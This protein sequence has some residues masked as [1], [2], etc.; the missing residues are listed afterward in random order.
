MKLITHLHPVPRLRMR[1]ALPPFSLHDVVLRHGDN[2]SN[3]YSRFLLVEHP[4]FLTRPTVLPQLIKSR[5]VN[6]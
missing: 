3:S 1:G 4:S 2:S 5:K 6:K